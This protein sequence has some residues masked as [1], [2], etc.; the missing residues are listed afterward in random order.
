MKRIIKNKFKKDITE[1]KDFEYDLDKFYVMY[2]E[3]IY[4]LLIDNF[5]T[6]YNFYSFDGVWFTDNKDIYDL[7]EEALEECAEIYEFNGFDD[8]VEFYKD[9]K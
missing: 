7:F 3:D 8:F 1:L 2:L 5:R 4:W 6:N 9:N